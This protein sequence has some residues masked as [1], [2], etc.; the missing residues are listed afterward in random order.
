M[1]NDHYDSSSSAPAPA[2]ARS[3][4]RWRRGGKRILLLE[5]GDFLPR[6][7][8]LGPEPVFV[9]GRYISKETWYDD[10]GT[11]FQ[12]QVHYYVG[13]RRSCTAPRCTGCGPRTSASCTT[14]TASRRRGR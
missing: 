3:P 8:E 12:P 9:D 6:D 10:D 11:A 14:S 7:G 1:S 2:A 13:A 4:R 5:R